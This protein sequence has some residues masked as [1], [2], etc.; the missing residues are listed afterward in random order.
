MIVLANMGVPMLFIQM[1]AMLFALAPVIC[2][3]AIFARSRLSLS[4]REAFTAVTVANL[5][6]TIIGFPIA[7]VLLVVGQVNLETT[8][9]RLPAHFHGDLESPLWRTYEMLTTFAWLNPD[10]TNLYWMIPIAS[11]LLLIPSYFASVWL[12]RPVC[13]SLWKHIAPAAVSSVVTRANQ[14][15]YA[16]LF[17]FACLWLGWELLTHH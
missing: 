14:L 8:F 11:A 10:E 5:L 17:L 13:R 3:E 6:S 16:A 2:I 1:P 4:R 12:E 7:W 9:R 15:S